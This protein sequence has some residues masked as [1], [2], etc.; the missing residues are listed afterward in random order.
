[1]LRSWPCVG[2]LHRTWL[3]HTHSGVC[4]CRKARINHGKLNNLRL[5]RPAFGTG[6]AKVVQRRHA[7]AMYLPL[8]SIDYVPDALTFCFH[9]NRLGMVV[10][11]MDAVEFSLKWCSILKGYDKQW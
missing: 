1:M 8:I 11:I 6:N 4:R 5:Q 10:N 3:L 9:A 2:S 7:Y